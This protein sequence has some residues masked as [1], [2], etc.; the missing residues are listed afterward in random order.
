LGRHPACDVRLEDARVSGEHASLHW[1]GDTWELRDLGSK[2]GTFLEGRRLVPGERVA[3]QAGQSFLLGPS[4]TGFQLVDAGPPAAR[5]RHA[6]SGRVQES[7]GSLLV[8]P[9]DE[10]PLASI[11]LEGSGRWLLESCE[12][13]RHVADQERLLLGGEEWVL[14]LPSATTETLEGDVSGLES[15]HLK[16]G[17]SRDEEHVVV[18]LVHGNQHTVLAPRSHHYLL[19]TLARIRLKEHELPEA[20]RGWVERDM[21]CQML[22]T[23]SNKLNVDIH[24]VRKQLSTLGIQDAASIVE[25]RSGTGQLRL[26]VRSVEVFS[27]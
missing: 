11:F 1:R 23:D 26:G 17:V 22:A 14:E 2:N 24:R 6:T 12:E 27:L 20:E 3:L 4:G 8:L 19:A 5:A 13:R 21:L 15:L 25:R 9:D 18:T 7:A 16:I 10:H